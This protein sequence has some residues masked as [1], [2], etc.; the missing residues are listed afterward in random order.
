MIRSISISG[1]LLA[2]LFCGVASAQQA[3]L[4]TSPS[5][6][7]KSESDVVVLR[8][9]GEPVT[10]HQVMEAMDQIAGLQ[11]TVVDQP[12]QRNAILYQDAIEN[13]I[14]IALLKNQARRQN[15]TIDK[16]TVDQQVQD[17]SKQFATPEDFQKALTRQGVTESD[18]RKN[19]EESMSMQTV[20]DMAVQDV[21]AATEEEMKKF[22]DDN[23]GKFVMPERVR[24]GHIL[25]LANS[26]NTPEQKAEI[27]KKLEGIRAEIANKTITFADAA[28]KYS[29]DPTTAS[30]GGDLDLVLRGRMVKA[31]EDA[32]FAVEPDT[33]TP[34]V[35]TPV[36]FHII[37]VRE[38]LPSGKAS[39]EEAKPALRKYLDQAN[40]QKAA[41]QYVSG[42]KEKATIETF[43]TPEE[44]LK[45]HP[46][47]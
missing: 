46:L 26:K 35:E 38:K 8:V 16:R 34:V 20:L 7:A 40:K 18:L 31:F 32:A 21:P 19:I 27:K 36:G 10:E 41:E 25:L 2:A 45:R 13:L 43:M 15:I 28:R 17:F 23:P 6:A 12:K 3:T 4:A 29:E 44:F 5:Q 22:Y 47:K 14:T 30:K 37:Q 33:I 11:K 1:I 24:A 9:S 42:L 39:F